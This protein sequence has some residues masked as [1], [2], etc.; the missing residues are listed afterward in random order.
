M[1]CKQCSKEFVNN[2]EWQKFCSEDCG[3]KYRNSG[4]EEKKCEFCNKTYTGRKNQKY[5]SKICRSKS[6]IKDNEKVCPICKNK[7]KPEHT[8]NIFCSRKCSSKNKSNKSIIK[9][10][11]S[12]CNKKVER[13]KSLIRKY[14]F[15]SRACMGKYYSE[16]RFGKIHPLWNGGKIDGRGYKWRELRKEILV[17]D[18]F[19]CRICNIKP[20]NTTNLDVHHIVKYRNFDNSKDANNLS[21][22]LLV[23]KKCHT[24]IFTNK[25]L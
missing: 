3:I 1:K 24:K 22:L 21:N 11:C 18:N 7:F 17:R 10:E 12:Y 8:H 14:T 25:G 15:C 20:K 2:R 16:N 9:T 6:L 19:S 5:C 4:K 23:C 13:P